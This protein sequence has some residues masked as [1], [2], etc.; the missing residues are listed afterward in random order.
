M[1]TTVLGLLGIILLLAFLVESLVEAL[2]GPAFDKIA[3]LTPWKWCLMY[4]AMIAGVIGAFV[5]GF[6][7]LA[8][9]SAYLK[10]NL[11]STPFGILLTGLAI[12]RGSNYVHDIVTRFF[13][14]ETPAEP[15]S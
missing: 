5:Y 11:P 6:D 15:Q 8:L 9:L 4:V 14:P 2:F 10:V 13:K 3:I 7:L 1:D 12:G